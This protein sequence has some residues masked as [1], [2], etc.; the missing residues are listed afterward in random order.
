MKNFQFLNS[1]SL[2]QDF[3]KMLL[4][5]FIGWLGLNLA[6]TNDLA[7]EQMIRLHIFANSDSIYDQ[8]V[9]LLVKD[10]VQEY[11]NELLLTAETPTEI[12]NIL[13]ANM[14]TIDNLADEIAQNY[15]YGAQTEFGIF[16]FTERT[17]D[18]YTMEAGEYKALKISL[19][20]GEGHNWFCVL[21]PE[22]NFSDYI[23]NLKKTN[24]KDNVKV[25]MDSF[26]WQFI[27]DKISWTNQ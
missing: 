7:E 15:G 3:W 1:T 12:E 2:Q 25:E 22:M 23:G 9:K 5:L 13:T 4:L 10:S 20:N 19:G 16:D 24:S 14:E 18:G 6:I 17:L 21:Y 11:V 27:K 26:I 8:Q